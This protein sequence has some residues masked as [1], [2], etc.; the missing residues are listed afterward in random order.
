MLTQVSFYDNMSY[1]KDRDKLYEQIQDY[2]KLLQK[3][4][5]KID[6]I[7]RLINFGAFYTHARDA[8][9]FCVHPVNKWDAFYDYKAFTDIAWSQYWNRDV[10]DDK[11][12][13]HRFICDVTQD[14]RMMYYVYR[15]RT[16]LNITRKAHIQEHYIEFKK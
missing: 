5:D 14:D 4:T 11:P 9:L 15:T 8:F 12:E 2:G 6:D 16:D 10:I 7:I 13:M 3:P 1:L